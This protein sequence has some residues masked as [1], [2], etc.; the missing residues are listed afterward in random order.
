[1]NFKFNKL[2]TQCNA[3]YKQSS[4]NWTAGQKSKDDDVHH[5]VLGTSHHHNSNWY[6]HLLQGKETWTHIS[7]I[8]LSQ[9]KKMQEEDKRI[10]VRKE[11]ERRTEKVWLGEIFPTK[12]CLFFGSSLPPLASPLWSSEHCFFLLS[13]PPP[14]FSPVWT[15]SVEPAHICWED[16]PWFYFAS[17]QVDHSSASW[18]CWVPSSLSLASPIFQASSW[19]QLVQRT[20]L[21]L[22]LLKHF[23]K[24]S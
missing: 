7:I 4:T 19:K 1:M 13:P 8:C 3:L 9:M 17:W 10:S 16:L 20:S 12:M 23:V 22:W 15:M 14:F 11:N 6:C 18:W 5:G 21:I 2:L 24:F